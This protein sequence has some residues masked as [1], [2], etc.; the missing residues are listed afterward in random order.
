[1]LG[2]IIAGVG[3]PSYPYSILCHHPLKGRT[4]AQCRM[5][6]VL[7]QNFYVHVQ[8]DSN[9]KDARLSRFA[10][11]LPLQERHKRALVQQAAQKN[12]DI[13]NYG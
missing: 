8:G 7:A 4:P 1:M 11:A 5:T 3:Y 13:H 9:S 10:A 6:F 2:R 12:L